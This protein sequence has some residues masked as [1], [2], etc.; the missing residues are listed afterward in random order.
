MAR[1]F[2]TIDDLIDATYGSNIF[3]AGRIRKDAPVLTSTAGAANNIYGA[4]VFAG[5]VTEANAFGVLP[6]KPWSKSGYRAAQAASATSGGG[7]SEGGAIPATVKASY[8]QCDM[9][10]KTM[11][12]AFDMSTLQLG[13]EGK[14]DVLTWQAHRDLEA[15]TFKNLVNRA[16]LADGNAD[17]TALTVFDSI[18][19][20]VAT[21][22]ADVTGCGNTASYEDPWGLLDRSATSSGND[23]YGSWADAQI[24]H[25]GST[26]TE[27]DREFSLSY[28]DTVFAACAPYWKN[29]INNKVFITGYDTFMDWSQEMLPQQMLPLTRVKLGVNGIESLGNTDT[30][31]LVNAYNGIPIILSN[32]VAQDTK[33]RIYL[34]DL[35]YMGIDLISPLTYY[36]SEDYQAIDK[37]AREGVFKIEG[38]LVTTKFRGQGKIRGLK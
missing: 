13:I 20:H 33:S 1:I 18:D 27:T 25:G 21:T 14:D 22:A 36:E 31:L 9:S 7:V 12:N 2:N 30:G 5:F 37:F 38:E 6:K 28:I 4:E 34:L 24:S 23:N 11:A 16:L 29:G 15:E 32:N 10:K 26:G 8:F 35:D 3:N 19:R 17:P